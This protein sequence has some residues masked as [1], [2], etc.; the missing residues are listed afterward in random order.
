MKQVPHQVRLNS[1]CVTG[2][3]GLG[4]CDVLDG[5]EFEPPVLLG[6]IDQRLGLLDL[7]PTIEQ[8]ELHIIVDSHRA[9]F[10]AADATLKLNVAGRYRLSDILKALGRPADGVRKSTRIV[11]RVLRASLLTTPTE[12][13]VKSAAVVRLQSDALGS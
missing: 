4:G 1:R 2:M 13:G 8:R 10:L 11:A 3:P 7:E 12:A 6:L 5:D 9:F